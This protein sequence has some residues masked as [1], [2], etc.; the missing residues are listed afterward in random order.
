MAT[1][2]SCMAQCS[3]LRGGGQEAP[4]GSAEPA[5]FIYLLLGI[6]ASALVLTRGAKG[7]VEEMKASR[8]SHQTHTLETPSLSSR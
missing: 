8:K 6:G 5:G 4:V 1:L 2:D 7:L 3:F